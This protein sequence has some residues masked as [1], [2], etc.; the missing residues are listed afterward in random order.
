MRKQPLVSGAFAAALA[1][2]GALPILGRP[3]AAADGGTVSITLPEDHDTF[4]PGPDL[5]LVQ[6]FCAACHAP[7]YVYTQP[8]LTRAQWHAEVTKMQRTY[9]C[10]LPDSAVDGLVEYLMS[11]NGKAD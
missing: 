4:Q 7:D 8:P 9:H 3:A 6:G 5:D 2:V 11:Q 1:L 10:P